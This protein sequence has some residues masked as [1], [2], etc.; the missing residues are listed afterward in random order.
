M[1]AALALAALL[2]D[3]KTDDT[4]AWNDAI[5]KAKAGRDRQVEL[6]AGRC[7][8]K[9]APA[10]IEK[11][12]S[13]KGQGKSSTILESQFSGGAFIRVLDNGSTLEDFAIWAGEGVFGGVGLSLSAASG[14]SGNHVL[15]HLW[16]TSGYGSTWGVPLHVDGSMQRAAPVGIRTVT[17]HDVSVF[18][19]VSWAAVFW[20][21]IGCEW[22]GGG[23]YRGAGMTQAI[24]VGGGSV[25]MRI[26]AMIDWPASTVW[27]GAM[28]Q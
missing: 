6:P 1:L 3:G 10:P 26:D 11:G 15:K 14:A 25:N 27:A 28:R 5:A 18:N 7:V 23:A 24:A 4:Q 22:F 16:I 9:S 17:L 2:C 21:C 20:N 12:V 13:V 19:G 8:F